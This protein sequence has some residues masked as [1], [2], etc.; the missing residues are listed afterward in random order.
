MRM[1]NV[2]EQTFKV[3]SR[4]LDAHNYH[5]LQAVEPTSYDS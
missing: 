4:F 2:A 1:Y 5:L 3:L